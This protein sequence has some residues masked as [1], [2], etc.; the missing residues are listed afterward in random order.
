MRVESRNKQITYIVK[1]AAQGIVP[2]YDSFIVTSPHNVIVRFSDIEFL[3]RPGVAFISFS[4]ILTSQFQFADTP[5]YTS[6]P[7]RDD[8]SARLGRNAN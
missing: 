3:S 6:T 1:L 2:W 4:P 7:A 8:T 5:C